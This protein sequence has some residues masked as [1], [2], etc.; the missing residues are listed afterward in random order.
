MTPQEAVKHLR[1]YIGKRGEHHYACET[2]RGSPKFVIAGDI[3]KCNCYA[4]GRE[5]AHKALDELE[6]LCE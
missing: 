1:S 2:V 6:K 5:E 3:A 4:R